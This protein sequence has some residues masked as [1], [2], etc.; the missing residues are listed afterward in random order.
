MPRASANEVGAT[1]RALG[2]RLALALGG[3]ACSSQAGGGPTAQESTPSL[4]PSATTTVS[5]PLPGAEPEVKVVPS[6][7]PSTCRSALGTE[8]I[9]FTDSNPRPSQREY[10]EAYSYLLQVVPG[11]CPPTHVDITVTGHGIVGGVRARMVTTS[12][13]VELLAEPQP[14][15]PDSGTWS[16]DVGPGHL[17]GK[18]LFSRGR[19]TGLVVPAPK[20]PNGGLPVFHADKPLA[21]E[22]EP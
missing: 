19:A 5:A 18:I 12:D 7:T 13:G 10:P 2:W 6:S 8:S 3:A 21:P 14:T 15:D 4:G 20:K 1:W 17:L 11:P 16:P 9:S 22:P